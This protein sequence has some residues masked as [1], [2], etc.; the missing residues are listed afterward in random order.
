M[1]MTIAAFKQ[2]FLDSAKAKN[3]KIRW[4]MPEKRWQTQT[5]LAPVK[6]ALD[7]LESC[8]IADR[9]ARVLDVRNAM[10]DV[11]AKRKTKYAEALALVENG[12]KQTV[13]ESVPSV[14]GPPAINKTMSDD[15]K[16]AFV[17]K[18]GDDEVTL[19]SELTKT[20]ADFVHNLMGELN[21]LA[22]SAGVAIDDLPGLVASVLKDTK[23]GASSDKV[24]D[25][26]WAQAIAHV[27]DKVLPGIK[28]DM[29]NM[30]ESG[31]LG[32]GATLKGIRFTGSDFHKGGK[33]VL[34]LRFKDGDEEKKVVYKP[35][36]LQVDALLFSGGS[37]A[38]KLGVSTYNIV[39]C[40]TE[41]VPPADYGY[42]A[43]VDT[44]GGP[45][46][47]ADVMKI[48]KSIAGAMAMAYYVGLE[49][50][51]HENVLM[52]KDAVQV[53]DMEATTGTFNMPSD[54]KAAMSGGFIDQQWKKAINDGFKMTLDRLINDG[55]LTELPADDAIEGEMCGEFSRVAARWADQALKTDLEG[56]ENALKGQKTRLVPIPTAALQEIIPIAQANTY[57]VGEDELPRTHANWILLVDD[58]TNK[59][60]AS[61]G[62]TMMANLKGTTSTPLPTVRN[63]VV[64]K[65]AWNALVRGDVPYYVRDLGSSDVFDEEGNKIAVAGMKKVG[66]NIAEEMAERRNAPPAAALKVF[67]VQGVAEIRK[68]NEA[69]RQKLG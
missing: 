65:G 62:S 45:S 49:D 54:D 58:R 17:T 1:V 15:G 50:V 55:K 39:P 23:M 18:D 67:K 32:D 24:S 4:G 9:P 16:Y 44:G 40:K 51:H 8:S 6:L 12:L 36:N 41:D 48:Y 60:G 27:R 63:L 34:I 66:K 3:K 29:D 33:Q 30:V 56:L 69:L 11:S 61:E 35:S 46:D 64:S 31:L 59:E 38:D 14:A 20:R 7:A 57:K 37:V 13:V 19:G 5:E 22:T 53:I 25:S 10:R 26:V 52:K 47:A 42:M 21:R 68:M 28:K 2:A 43:F